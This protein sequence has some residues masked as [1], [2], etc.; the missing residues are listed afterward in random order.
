MSTETWFAKENG[1]KRDMNVYLRQ[2]YRKKE[3][4]RTEPGTL[5]FLLLIV[6][7]KRNRQQDPRDIYRDLVSHVSRDLRDQA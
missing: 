4:D 6:T 2:Y 5:S 7:W 3:R 1:K